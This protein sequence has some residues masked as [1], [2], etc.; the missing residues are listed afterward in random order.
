MKRYKFSLIALAIFGLTLVGCEPQPEPAP[1]PE[2]EP[3]VIPTSFPRKHL[4]EEFTSQKCGYCPYG[5]DCIHDFMT[6]DTNFVLVL[7]H[8]G[9][10]ADNFSVKGSQSI[11]NALGVSGAPNMCID[12]AHTKS[13]AG[14]KV[15]FHPGY[16]PSV[17]K[18]QF[19]D[20]TY[21]SINIQN[22]YNASTRELSVNVSGIVCEVDSVD[23]QLTVLVKESGM[24]D[25]QQ[26]FEKTANGW[27][28][29]RH[30]NAVRAYLSASPKGDPITIEANRHYRETFTLTL[31]DKWI[32]DNC[33]VVAILSDSFKP[34]VQV[35][36]K[37][38]VEGTQGGA[39][40][41]HGGITPY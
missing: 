11:T 30:T 12:R 10:A 37:P 26:D 13:Y 27:K 8:Y 34:I 39:D 23:L 25:Y 41:V 22:T 18:A 1:E 33:M 4:I 40:I 7:H 38:V 28:E 35:A 17:N 29:F 3:E 5:M 16:L 24:I 21:A 31:K 32:A 19:V 20:T 2:P 9:F 14:N 15:V 6:N 36:Q